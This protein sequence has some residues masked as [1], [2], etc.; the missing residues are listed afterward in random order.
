MHPRRFAKTRFQKDSYLT[1]RIHFPNFSEKVVLDLIGAIY[2]A[3][4]DPPAWKIFLEKFAQ[5]VRGECTSLLWYDFRS[6]SGS[7][8]YSVRVK[9]EHIKLYDEYYAGVDVWAEGCKKKKVLQ[10]GR[11]FLGQEF[12]S[13][14]ELERSEFYADFLQPMNAYHQ[15]IGIISKDD[16]AV[17]AI[18]SLR[19]KKL[20]P[21]EE[22]LTLANLLM[23]HL[24]R[25]LQVH[26]RTLDLQS[27]LDGATQSLEHLRIGVVLVDREGKILFA[28]RTARLIAGQC[29]GFILSRDGLALA[30]ADE[31]RALRSLIQRASTTSE[32]HG[33][34]SGGVLCVSRPSLKRPYSI[35]V[36]PQPRNEMLFQ[37]IRPT[38]IVFVSDPEQEEQADEQI[39]SGLFGFTPAESRLAALLVQGKSIE[40]AAEANSVTRSTARSQ[41]KK[42]FEKTN[43]HR[44]GEL[45]RL[46]MTSPA[47][48]RRHAS[49]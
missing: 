2:D 16:C 40:E 18:S 13:N 35:L 25:A 38:A 37:S 30:R 33:V 31:S 39:L 5:A 12:C 3:A 47:I 19:P 42:V 1:G 14:Q 10:P 41:L 21:F 27:R 49:S 9:P 44:Q 20:H 48:L 45:I 22:E 28:N 4:I 46:L 11:V 6:L 34:D 23:P 26:F 17:G 36:A 7:I 29:D 32:G 8:S 24:K 15:I 43:T